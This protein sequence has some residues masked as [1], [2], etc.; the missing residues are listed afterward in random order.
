VILLSLAV[1]FCQNG[2]VAPG[3]ANRT[4]STREEFAQRQAAGRVLGTVADEDLGSGRIV[5]SEIEV[6]IML[7][8]LVYEVDE[9]WYKAMMRPNPVRTSA[10]M[11]A[12]TGSTSPVQSRLPF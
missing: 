9:R 6:P 3:Y 1:I 2:S 12:S 11:H 5:V 8:N 10:P 4:V 7:A